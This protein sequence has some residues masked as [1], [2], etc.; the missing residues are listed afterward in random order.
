MLV[1]VK[2]NNV[3][4]DMLCSMS[5]YRVVINFLRKGNRKTLPGKYSS[6]QSQQ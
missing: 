4:L 6:V 3:K 5:K 2:K 1:Q